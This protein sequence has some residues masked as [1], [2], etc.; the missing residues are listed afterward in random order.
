[1][2]RMPLCLATERMPVFVLELEQSEKGHSACLRGVLLA[3]ETMKTENKQPRKEIDAV[4][5]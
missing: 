5:T 1:M 4:K 3:V 2:T